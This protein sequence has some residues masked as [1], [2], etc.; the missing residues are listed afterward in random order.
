MLRRR[1]IYCLKS[2]QKASALWDHLGPR[3]GREISRWIVRQFIDIY[4]KRINVFP[5]TA[6]PFSALRPPAKEGGTEILLH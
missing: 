4:I 2:K 5:K 6:F 3:Q 1:I